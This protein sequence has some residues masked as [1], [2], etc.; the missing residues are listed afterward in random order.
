[1]TDGSELFA[2][3]CPFDI[4]RRWLGE[5]SLTEVNDPNAMA[6][7]TVGADGLPNVR[8]VLLK[9]LTAEG[10]VFY[11]NYESAKGQELS[12][13]PKAALVLHWK[14]LRRQVRMRGLVKPKD[15]KSADDY[16]ASRAFESRIGAWA[17][18]QSRPLQSRAVL[19]AEVASESA[20]HGSNPARPPYW[21]G[22]CLEPVEIE[23]WADGAFR[24]HDRFVWRRSH[25]GGAWQVERLYP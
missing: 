5:A 25:P 7:A 20:R 23:F 22:F 4:A 19:E 6:L 14:T 1:M 18:K 9:D 3:D 8:M 2:G 24:L 21:G 11:T 13:Q 17:S 16:Y 10:A 12:A 15:G